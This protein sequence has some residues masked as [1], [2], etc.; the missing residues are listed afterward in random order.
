MKNYYNK[1][2]LATAISIC[3]CTFSSCK[4]YLE[5]PLPTNSLST[6][7]AFNSKSVIDGLMNQMYIDFVDKS[8]FQ[9]TNRLV[10][11]VSDNVYNPTSTLILDYQ[12][13]NITPLIDRGNIIVWGDAYRS[14]Y[15][16]NTMLEGLPGASGVGVTDALKKE[17]IAAAKTVRAYTYFQLVRTYGDVPLLITTNVEENKQKA[18]TAKAEVYALIEKDLKEA[19]PDLPST[20]G[21]KYRINNKFIPEAILANVYLTQGK[22]AEA[23][24]SATNIIASNKFQLATNVNDVFLQTSP[25]TISA[26][27]YTTESNRVNSPKTAAVASSFLPQGSYAIF[28]EETMPALSVNLINSFEPGD[29]RK[30][31]WTLLS[32]AGGY[33]NPLNRMFCY[34]YK[35]NVTYYQGTIPAGREEDFKFIRLAEVYLIRAEARAQQS[36]L[37]E[38]ASD[39]DKIRNRA[40]LLNTTAATKSDLIEAVLKERRVELFCENGSR[41]F[42]LVRTGKADAVLSALSYKTNWKPYMV[43]FPLRIND[44]NANLNLTQNPGYN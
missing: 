23:E 19:I 2:L 15:M 41:W 6:A 25:E 37:T 31:N 36:K 44:L 14:I 42:D 11:A 18:R 39:L 35:Y 9:I 10:E 17:Y 12:I 20:P 3:V 24:A 7:S 22:W 40:G 21:V 4:K 32:N 13:N 29:L 26:L 5:I 28:F 30:A 33:P 8:T 43:L 27:G 34:K 38:G 16:A 1:L